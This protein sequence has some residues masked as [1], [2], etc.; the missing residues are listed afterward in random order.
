MKKL[1]FS[2]LLFAQF[3]QFPTRGLGFYPKDASESDI[4]R[5]N[6]PSTKTLQYTHKEYNAA[7]SILGGVMAS[8]FLVGP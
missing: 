1:L 4:P 8:Q 2:C 7:N 6:I 5:N 3:S